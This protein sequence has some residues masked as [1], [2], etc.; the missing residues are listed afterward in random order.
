MLS[1]CYDIES[2]ENVFTLANFRCE[3]NVIEM[4]YLCDDISLIPPNFEA[5]ATQRIHASN[6]N[7]DGTVEFYDLRIPESNFKLARTF[8]LS[9]AYYANNPNNKSSYSDEY[10]LVCDTDPD[11]DENI[12]P[13]FFGYNSFH[14]DTTMLTMYMYDAIDDKD[15]SFH[16]QTAARMRQYNDELFTDMFNGPCRNMEDRL[17]YEYKD[18]F[19][20]S[21]GY[22]Q[23]N[24]KLPIAVIRKNMLLSGR[25]LDVARLNEKQSKVGLKRILGM[26]GY[27]ILESDKLRPGQDRIENSEQ[28]IDLFAY[29]VS[30]VVNLKKLLKHKTYTSGFSL[31]KQLLKTYP[32]LVYSEKNDTYKP[33]ISP[34]S[35]RNDRLT[36][37]SSSAQFATKALCPYGH[38]HDYDTVSFMYPSEAKSKEL[39]IPRVNVLEEAK[40]FFYNNFAQPELRARFDEIY[41]YYKAIEGKNF[42]AG[43]NYLIDHNIDLESSPEP[44]LL[45]PEELKVW[46]FSD[47]PAPN[48]CMFYYQKD[49]TPSTCFV[50]FSTGGIH[51]A[52]YNQA[53]YNYDM[54][55]WQE[56]VEKWQ[57]TVDLIEEVKKIYPNPCDLKINKGVTI[58]GVKYTPS[59][60]L[61][62]KATATEAYYKEWPAEPTPPVLF[63]ESKSQ[64]TGAVT[65][66]LNNRYAYTSAAMTNHED[67]TSYYPN[68]LR[69]MDAF[70]N[71]GLGYDRYGE[72]FDDKTRYGILMKDETLSQVERDLYA[73][74]REG[75]KLILNSASGA[76]DASF[77]SNVRMNNKII[78]MRIIGQLFTWRIGQA[79]TIEGAK[80]ISTNTDGLYSVLEE[81]RNAE[82]LARE[83]ESIH[84]EIEPE[85]IFLISKDSNNRTE[86]K[87]KNGQLADVVG[88]SGGT[89]SCRKG[90]SP[91]KSLA[92]PAI[93]DWSL[94]EYLS[95]AS[96]GYKGLSLEKPFDDDIGRSIISSA[97]QIFNDDVQTLLMFQNVIASS[98]GSQRFVFATTDADPTTAIPLQ[99]YNRCFIAKD[100]TN[101][102]YHLKAASAKVIT[103]SMQKKRA[104]MNERAQQHDP[105][106][107]TILAVN[108]VKSNSL[109]LNKEATV[110]K[111]TGVEENWYMI[112]DNRDL[113]LLPQD[114]INRI[115]DNLDYD[116][117]LSLLRDSFENNWRNMTPEWEQAEAEAK[118][119]SKEKTEPTPLFSKEEV[120]QALNKLNYGKT[121][122]SADSVP[123][124][125]QTNDNAV[126]SDENTADDCP[127][128]PIPMDELNIPKLVQV[129]KTLLSNVDIH[130]G[131]HHLC[132]NGIREI[133]AHSVLS[134]LLKIMMD[135][136]IDN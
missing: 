3:D 24:Y 19:R 40:T 123:A 34:Y 82:I 75:T 136:D 32:E 9:D 72:I 46:K 10:R 21:L 35:V 132:M 128:E 78:S 16:C 55:K 107:T 39:G 89:L 7:F 126:N 127:P 14:Y 119:N 56:K 25:H 101:G 71:A 57:E 33:D 42:N 104:K 77:E 97:R 86:I 4:Y 130:N 1:Y 111:I 23:Q 129:K 80:M 120:E 37:D 26:L 91:T 121:D 61:K 29:N 106:A 76:G 105:M 122:E 112:V 98:P 63:K 95:I 84:V 66:T 43:K 18:P 81:K 58:N 100:G 96:I 54:E 115:L 48:T 103:D 125:S 49:G 87:I 38:L 8:G 28:L 65:Y 60:F 134:K 41:N 20:P 118:K 36:I 90:P 50:N 52:E 79:Q 22:T 92:H 6:K 114:E 110:T 30:D 99:H 67:F 83:S 53:L 15:G 12:H 27:Q 13:Y 69:M 44:E 74:M 108:G 64:A 70:F 116:K 113:H 5:V 17:R 93:I 102:A 124:Q 62:P 45:L 59:T 85:P 133:D 47:I 68:M 117:Y 2:L 135:T 94:T 131:E 11:Y 31:K 88:A 109:P 73:V 51:G